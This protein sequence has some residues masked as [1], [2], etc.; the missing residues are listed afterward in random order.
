VYG[1]SINIVLSLLNGREMSKIKDE[2]KSFK[3][4]KACGNCKNS[5]DEGC[6]G[7][8]CWE[9]SFRPE[10]IFWVCDN[11]ECCENPELVGGTQKVEKEVK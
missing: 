5:Q 9:H 7:I 4:V 8:W 2:P 10:D 6:E 11:W 3:K 1:S